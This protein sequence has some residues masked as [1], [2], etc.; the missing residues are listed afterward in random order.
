MSAYFNLAARTAPVKPTTSSETGN[1]TA[2]GVAA[3]LM[4]ASCELL[5]STGRA[6]LGPERSGA[7][8]GAL[9]AGEEPCS[10]PRPA[11]EIFGTP[12]PSGSGRAL[13][14]AFARSRAPAHAAAASDGREG[15]QSRRWGIS[16]LVTSARSCPASPTPRVPRRATDGRQ[17]SIAIVANRSSRVGTGQSVFRRDRNRRTRVVGMAKGIVREASAP[18]RIE[19]PAGQREAGCT[20]GSSP[21]YPS[22]STSSTWPASSSA[23]GVWEIRCH[24]GPLSAAVRGAGGRG[25]GGGRPG[26]SLPGGPSRADSGCR[27]GGGAG[28]RRVR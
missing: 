5:A 9:S 6:E 21:A 24:G 13:V 20:R 25:S 16:G 4:L 2:G 7:S 15:G 3:A 14:R 18:A 11:L 17:Q 8:S 12:G 10:E 27:V 22:V 23:R 26:G 28:R 1:A 19:S